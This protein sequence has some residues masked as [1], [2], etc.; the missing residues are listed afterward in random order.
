MIDAHA[1]A[2]EDLSRAIAFDVSNAEI[3][4]LRGDAY[5]AARDMPAALRDYEQALKLAPRLLAAHTGRGL[6]H[7]RL[8]AWD[9]AFADL[10]RAIE[11]DP[12]SPIAFAYRAFIY[13]ETGQVAVGLRDI[14]TALKLDGKRAEV[15]WAR[16]E[17]LEAQGQIDD[18]IADFERALA[19]RPGYRDAA[20]GLLRLGAT[21]ALRA[22][23]VVKGAGIDPWR[24]VQRS[25]QFFAV[26]ELYP[27]LSIPLEMFGDGTPKL[28]EWEERP[29][30]HDAFGLLRFSGGT[31]KTQ[32]NNAPSEFIAL[33]E[34]PQ[35]RVLAIVPQREGNKTSAWTWEGDRV[36]V[37]ALDGMTEE[38]QVRS[39]PLTGAAPGASAA[40]RRSTAGANQPVNAPAWAPWDE[41]MAATGTPSGAGAKKQA[42][43]QKKKKPKTLFELLFN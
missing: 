3:Y 10:N 28:L 20:D 7:A 17:I 36:T 13:K 33:I 26:S 16:A 18:A 12:R 11:I 4:A 1:E 32:P 42:R 5:L 41:P 29:P 22:E 19:L 30:P 9:E 34:L 23:S 31:P 25:G 6:A 37:A 40:T 27:R 15:Y 8:Q 38:F 2:I 43:S 35:Q 39:N 14:D 24:V 21:E